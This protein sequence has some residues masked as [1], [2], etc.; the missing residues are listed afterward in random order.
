MV[1]HNNSHVRKVRAFCLRQLR[2]QHEWISR[3][4]VLY[5]VCVG[6]MVVSK[7]K[8]F[9]ADLERLSSRQVKKP[10]RALV[11]ATLGRDAV[12]YRLTSTG[13]HSLVKALAKEGAQQ[14]EPQG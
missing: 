7:N 13:F 1:N 5:T 12:K 9:C 10:E 2:Q 11:E 4:F 6:T 8:A 14:S 3:L